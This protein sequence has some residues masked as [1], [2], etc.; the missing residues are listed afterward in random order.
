MS[1]P[2]AAPIIATNINTGAVVEYIDTRTGTAAKS[3]YTE[4]LTNLGT[5]NANKVML[6]IIQW[7][8]PNTQFVN[9]VEFGGVSAGGCTQIY[10]QGS[11]F[12]YRIGSAMFYIDYNKDLGGPSPEDAFYVE[13]NLGGT[14]INRFHIHIY[15]IYNLASLTPVA[16]GTESQLQ[17]NEIAGTISVPSNGVGVA[18]GIF[19]STQSTT[20]TGSMTE[21]LNALGG[22]DYRY[23]TAY[24]SDS[25]SQ[26]YDWAWSSTVRLGGG[27]STWQ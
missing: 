8:E 12:I 3:Y 9:W 11:D 24:T 13:F 25:G 19:D 10:D 20:Y 27:W 16:S 26:T 5:A 14:N 15:S 17:D 22:S 7:E 4:T 18:Q 1:L 21:H 6:V 23:M 2:S